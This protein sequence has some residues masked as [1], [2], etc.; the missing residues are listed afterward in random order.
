MKNLSTESPEKI[1]RNDFNFDSAVLIENDYKVNPMFSADT[2]LENPIYHTI[3][4]EYESSENLHKNFD[5]HNKTYRNW[6]M[7]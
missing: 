4:N 1:K 3:D 7:S 2:V 6:N 5:S